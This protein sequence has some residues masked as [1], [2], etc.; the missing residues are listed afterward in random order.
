MI[1]NRKGAKIAEYQIEIGRVRCALR[2]Y[3]YAHSTRQHCGLL[4]LR[5]SKPQTT[6][7][8]NPQVM[9]SKVLCS[10]GIFP[11]HVKCYTPITSFCHLLYSFFLIPFLY[12]RS[13]CLKT[14]VIK[15]ISSP[16]KKELDQIII[17]IWLLAN[18][19]V[20]SKKQFCQNATI[21]AG[22]LHLPLV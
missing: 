10:L 12:Q 21:F 18:K 6:T 16:L 15:L 11:L 22:K 5:G 17:I 2:F 7:N 4:P 19:I 14:K 3:C 1:R 20:T 8:K 9:I 13:V